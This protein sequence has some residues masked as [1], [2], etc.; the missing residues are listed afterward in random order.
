[1]KSSDI[2]PINVL[3]FITDLELIVVA[4]EPQFLAMLVYAPVVSVIVY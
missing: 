2:N 1:M 3:Q 4:S